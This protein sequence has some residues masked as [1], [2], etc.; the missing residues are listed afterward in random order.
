MAATAKL[1]PSQLPDNA[2]V[3]ASWTTSSIASSTTA[4]SSR[5]NLL[6]LL[7]TCW[8]AIR[9]PVMMLGTNG[10]VTGF[11]SAQ[12]MVATNQAISTAME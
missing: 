4:T 1:S 5:T 6:S 8:T 7:K 12:L 9:A 11:D 2:L 3:T 10:I